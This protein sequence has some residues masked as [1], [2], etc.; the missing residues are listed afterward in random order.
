MFRVQSFTDETNAF[1]KKKEKETA[2]TLQIQSLS[3]A[4]S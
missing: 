3:L 1:G 4:I 2:N